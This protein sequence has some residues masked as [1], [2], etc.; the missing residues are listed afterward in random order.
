[1]GTSG[2]YSVAPNTST[3][4]VVT[5]VT[6]DTASGSVRIVP[7]GGGAVPTTMEIF[8]FKPIGVTVSEAGVP[9]TMGT[10]FRLFAQLSQSPHIVSGI[11]IANTG[12]TQGT[13][14][15]T[16]N[17]FDGSAPVSLTKTLPPSGTATGF[18]DQ[19]IPALAGQTAQG[20]LSISTNLPSI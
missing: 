4:I 16:F 5:G 19:L 9:V 14:T 15:L 20:V 8:S 13:V 18:L 11:A 7:T 2:A 17:N 3:K 10:N 6:A 12:S 1:A